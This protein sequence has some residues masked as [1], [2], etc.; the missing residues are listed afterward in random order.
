MGRDT[1]WAGTLGGQGGKLAL[2]NEKQGGK[3]QI[4]AGKPILWHA[5]TVGEGG[6]ILDACLGRWTALFWYWS[7]HFLTACQQPLYCDLGTDW[8]L[9]ASEIQMHV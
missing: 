5:L 7:H 2:M 1:G 4:K 8:A 9:K 6:A 3:E